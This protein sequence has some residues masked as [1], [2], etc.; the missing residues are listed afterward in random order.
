MA[1]YTKQ[2]NHLLV[3]QKDTDHEGQ[4]ELFEQALTEILG[5]KHTQEPTDDPMLRVRIF[6]TAIDSE[7]R[8]VSAR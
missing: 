5:E 7:G 2:H 3:G 6:N 1:R 8:K 4:D